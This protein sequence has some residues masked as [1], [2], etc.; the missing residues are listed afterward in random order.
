MTTV[1]TLVIGIMVLLIGSPKRALS[2]GR[3]QVL[4]ALNG[5]LIGAGILAMQLS[6][7][8]GTV[9]LTASL[10]STT[11]IWALALSVFFF[12]NEKLEW[13]HGAV[14]VMVCVGAILIVTGQLNT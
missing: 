7:I 1:S 11:P 6:L 8:S 14:A 4:F 12:K 5:V 9:S 10:V 13:W 3:G 2:P